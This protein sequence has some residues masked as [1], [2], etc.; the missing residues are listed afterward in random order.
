[1]ATLISFKEQHDSVSKKAAL[2]DKLEVELSNHLLD[3]AE[4]D[5]R[6]SEFSMQIVILQNKTDSLLSKV[7]LIFTVR[8][9]NFPDLKLCMRR[10]QRKTKYTLRYKS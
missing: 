3:N 6:M 7:R 4:K 10:R 5:E 2:C 1:M 8:L 9:H